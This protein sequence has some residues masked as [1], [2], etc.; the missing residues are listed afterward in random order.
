[1]QV[2]PTPHICHGCRYVCMVPRRMASAAVLEQR[3]RALQ[4]Q[5]TLLHRPHIFA[6]AQSVR[7]KRGSTPA[8][9][10][11]AAEDATAGDGTSKIIADAKGTLV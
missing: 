8:P 7:S 9:E 2:P 6:V 10:A 3:K 11:K 5:L 4:Q 1:M